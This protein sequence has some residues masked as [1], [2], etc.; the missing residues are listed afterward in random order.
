MRKELY[1][2]I[3]GVLAVEPKLVLNLEKKSIF[4]TYL[5]ILSE[6]APPAWRGLENLL[7]LQRTYWI[8]KLLYGIL[9]LN[10]TTIPLVCCLRGRRQ[11]YYQHV[12]Y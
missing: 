2:K 9:T 10:P 6:I 1:L 7:S 3:Q 11:Y 12:L 5:C 4:L 8:S